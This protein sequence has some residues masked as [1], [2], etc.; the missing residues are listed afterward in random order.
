MSQSDEYTENRHE[1]E[2]C[3]TEKVGGL[4]ELTS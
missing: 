2:V 4:W 1:E 3:L